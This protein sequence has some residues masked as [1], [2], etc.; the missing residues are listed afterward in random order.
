MS[1]HPNRKRINLFG[2]PLDLMS[3]Q[4]LLDNASR[5]LAGEYRLR[6]EGLNVAKLVDA[7]GDTQ[8]MSALE[9]AERVHVDGAGIALGLRL[10]GISAPPR[11]AGIDLLGDLCALAEK[12]GA[13]V[14]LLGARREVVELTAHYLRERYPA[15]RIAGIRDGYFKAE[16]EANVAEAIRASGADILF[17][18][19][20]SP[21]K[22]VLLQKH[23]PTLGVK[24]GMGVGGSFDVLSGKLPRA[25]RWVQVIGMEWFFRLILEPRRL[26]WRYVRTNGIY[27]TLLIHQKLKLSLARLAGA[28]SET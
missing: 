3:L 19:M 13:S 26:L 5:A 7:R 28:R 16:E 17:V 21:R 2:C 8:L 9:E 23:W 18:G 25:P 12:T 24:I 20:S 27:L 1:A 11:R 15:L 14:Y 6:L 10:L 4:D 22:E